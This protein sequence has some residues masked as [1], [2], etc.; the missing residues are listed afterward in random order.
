MADQRL[1]WDRLWAA[2]AVA[3]E[4]HVR[5]GRRH[6]LTE[7]VVRFATVTVL[8]ENGV[9]ADRLAAE[10]TVAGVGRVDLLVDPPTGAG[11]EFKFPREPS[12]MNAADTMAFGEILRDFYRLA[13]LDVADAWAVQM[14]R[15]ALRR[16]LARRQELVWVESP[17]GAVI[18][19][20]A[21]R[22]TVPMSARAALPEWAVGEVRAECRAAT[23]LGED[24]LVVFRVTPRRGKLIGSSALL[25]RGA[26]RITHRRHAPQRCSATGSRCE[27]DVRLRRLKR[28]LTVRAPL[29][30]RPM[31]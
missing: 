10:R 4:V 24:L 15:P 18:L 3:L 7:D 19:P 5:A 22:E 2:L 17:G 12:E 1:D 25:Y 29:A 27:T 21:L 11:V 14:L 13:R 8:A 16:Y 23:E 30:P 31:R 6:L 9:T 28:V 26:D 20:A